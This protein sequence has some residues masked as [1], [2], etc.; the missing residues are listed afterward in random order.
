MSERQCPYCGKFAPADASHCPHC[1][2]D[3]P[4]YAVGRPSYAPAGGGVEIR[5]G[6]LYML[7][8]AVFYFFAAGYSPLTFPL[9]YSAWLTDYA[10]PLLFLAGL[11]LLLYGIIR[12]YSR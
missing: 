4:V 7:L 9:P 3:L 1:H 8:A 12:H 2:E 11:G 10:L 5:R 6:L